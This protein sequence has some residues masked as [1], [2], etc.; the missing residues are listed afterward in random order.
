M[1][2]RTAPE[3]L[4]LGAAV[5]I[6][7]AHLFWASAAANAQWKDL[8][9]NMGPRDT[10]KPPLTGMAA[11]LQRAFANY[12]ETFPFFVAAV[13]SAYLAARLGER[14]LLGAWIYVIARALYLPMYAFGVPVGR[15]IVWLASVMGI[16]TVLSALVRA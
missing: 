8:K 16:L 6:G 7:F 14:T 9:W 15:T 4:L 5:L 1:E 12:R 10:P 13:L 11:R 3:L 2:P